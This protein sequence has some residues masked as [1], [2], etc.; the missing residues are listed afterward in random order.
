M[1]RINE[2]ALKKELAKR[3][4][5]SVSIKRDCRADASRST[6]RAGRRKGGDLRARSGDLIGGASGLRL[7]KGL[8]GQST[9]RLR[10]ALLV[11]GQH[12]NPLTFID[13]PSDQMEGCND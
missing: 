13:L 10:L 6:P 3:G 8:A 1:P 2:Q 9:S 11:P 12:S 5:E 7:A 4:F